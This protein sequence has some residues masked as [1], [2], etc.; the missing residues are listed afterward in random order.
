M[1]RPHTYLVRMAVFLA[2]VMLVTVLLS[3]A[4]VDAFASNPLLNGLI[5]LVLFVGIGWNLLN[6]RRLQPEVHWLETFQKQRSRLAALPPPRLLA[7]MASM[8][9]A[10]QA[11]ARD[12][13]RPATA[14]TASPSPPPPCAPSSTASPAASTKAAS[15]PAT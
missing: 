4:L 14:G 5:L 11:K 3:G 7:P 8:L 15:S 13:H 12:G 6:V 1:T 10:R 9:A 2:L